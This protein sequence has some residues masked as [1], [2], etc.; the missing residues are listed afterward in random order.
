MQTAAAAE[1]AFQWAQLQV[2]GGRRTQAVC[3]KEPVTVAGIM[4]FDKLSH[5]KP[6]RA[7]YHSTLAAALSSSML[8]IKIC[9]SRFCNATEVVRMDIRV[10][11]KSKC[12]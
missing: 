12:S 9:S 10:T 6:F 2:T 11:T 5:C 8:F 1:L 3:V 4:S 7:H